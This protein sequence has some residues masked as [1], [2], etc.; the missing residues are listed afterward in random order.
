MPSKPVSYWQEFSDCITRAIEGARHSIVV[1]GDFNADVASSGNAASRSVQLEHALAELGLKFFIRDPTRVTAS[2]ATTL[3]HILSSVEPSSVCEVLQ[4][5]TEEINQLVHWR[6]LSWSSHVVNMCL[7]N[8]YIQI[9]LP[10]PR[11]TI[12]HVTNFFS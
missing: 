4:I 10:V 11:Q 9:L 8:Q 5:E 2:S 7:F 3:D 12:L 1:V 6:N